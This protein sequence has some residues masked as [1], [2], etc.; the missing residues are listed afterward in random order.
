MKFVKSCI[1]IL[2]FVLLAIPV[3]A[4]T[5]AAK[6]STAC[7]LATLK[8]T[9][10]DFEQGTILAQFP[11]FPAPPY[12][13]VAS[14][15]V[16]Y[17][18]A[19]NVSAT[20]TASFGGVILPGTATGTYAV[21]PDCTYSDVIT[22][23]GGPGGHHVGTITGEGMFQEVHLMY[24]DP[25]LV[26]SAT[27]RKAPAGGCSQESLKGT[28]TIFGQGLSTLP[29]LPPLLPGVH[30]GIFTADGRGNFAGEETVTIAGQTGPPDTY[31]AKYIVN[32]DC[33]MSVAVTTNLGVFNEV[34]TITGVGRFQEY[35]GIFVEPG[36]V[37][38][39]TGEKQ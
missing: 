1:L 18:G 32:S 23:P 12:P 6:T 17:D 13:V 27:L 5:N 16:T 4:Q 39:E 34:G 24:T 3:V 35:H 8:G 20:Y 38:A 7:S 29:G 28:Y 30:V 19:G 11:G 2:A 14:G 9:Y 10:G 26:A 21:N 15:V 25:W 22:E 37:F 33:S 31:T 36:W